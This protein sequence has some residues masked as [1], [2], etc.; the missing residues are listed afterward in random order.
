MVYLNQDTIGE[1][2]KYLSFDQ[3][4]KLF[5]NKYFYEILSHYIE[6]IKTRNKRL[7]KKSNKN[8]RIP[9]FHGILYISK[10]KLNMKKIKLVYL[11]YMKFLYNWLYIMKIF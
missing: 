10:P 9:N 3:Y 7:Y 5:V 4:P 2:L 6:K 8:F 11:I 1:V